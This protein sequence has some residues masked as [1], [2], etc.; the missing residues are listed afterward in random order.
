MR[1]ALIHYGRLLASSALLLLVVITVL[2]LLLEIAPGDPLQAMLGDAPAS[3]EFRDQMVATFG[4]DQ[5][6]WQRYL[7]YVGNVLTGDLGESIVSRRSVTELIMIRAPY[8]LIIAVIALIIST[9]VCLVLGAIAARTRRPWLDGLISGGSLTFFSIPN[10][11]LGL[12]LIW[13]F[14]VVLDWL[15]ASGANAHGEPGIAWQYMIL[16]IVATATS[17]LALKTRVMRSSTIEALGQDYIDTAR[18][19]G[20]SSDRVLYRHGLPNALLPMITI[21]GLSVGNLLAGSTLIERVFGWPGMGLLMVDAINEK[22]N[23]VV[24]GVTI[25]MTVMIL[26]ANILTDIVYGLVDPRLR[27]RFTRSGRSAA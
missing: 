10:F 25:V 4:L 6:M 1:P 18:S 7:T 15:P 26:I 21:V 23:M 5:P 14:A 9:I 13:L 11:W 19:K 22:D 24:L 20:L 2:F 17:Q 8:T 27:A 16:P 3:E 12:M